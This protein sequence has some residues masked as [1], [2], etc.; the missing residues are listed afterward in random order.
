MMS[1][2]LY[3][4]RGLAHGFS[5]SAVAT[6][7]YVGVLSLLGGFHVGVFGWYGGGRLGSERTGA[8]R[9]LGAMMV[10]I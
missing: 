3:L 1:F 10:Y 7:S 8:L 6:E 4:P 5:S 2:L 9:M